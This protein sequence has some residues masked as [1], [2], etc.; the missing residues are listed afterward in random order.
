MATG[1]IYALLALGF[2]AVYRSMRLINFAQG[3]LFVTGAFI[4]LALA[5]HLHLSFAP[6]LTL[7]CLLLERCALAPYAGR[8][9]ELNIMIRTIGIAVVLQGAALI[10]WGTG[11]YHF[12]GLLR[13]A[14]ISLGRL[15]VPQH[16]LTLGAAALVLMLALA[17]FLRRT[18]MGLGMMA[19]SQDPH[20][21]AIIGID[22]AWS[23][24]LAFGI[25]AMLAGAAGVLT[26]P[27]WYVHYGVGTMVGLKGFTAAVLGGLGRFRGAVLGGLFLGVVENLTAG[28]LSSTWKDAVVFG[29]LLVALA[30]RP[31]GLL[32]LVHTPRT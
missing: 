9:P 15:D 13:T 29:I 25:S 2:A 18:R 4:G 17:V 7:T 23:R 14:T 30:L 3:D 32:G 8:A 26:A 12:P 19:A 1:F 11:E 10:I 31:Q 6:V 24:T 28:Y 16:L 22:T 20:G 5:Q 21:A 27:L